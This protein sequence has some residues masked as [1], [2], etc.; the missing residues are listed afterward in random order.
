[1]ILKSEDGLTELALRI[2]K[3]QF[4][5]ILH[6][7]DANWLIL[8]VEVLTV[9]RSLQATD[10]CLLTWEAHWLVNWLADVAMGSPCD[11]ELAF[12]EPDLSFP[13]AVAGEDWLELSVGLGYGLLPPE[14][15]TSGREGMPIPL[16]ITPVALREC[17]RDWAEEVLGLRL[18]GAGADSRE[19][20]L[21]VVSSQ[22]STQLNV[23]VPE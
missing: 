19:L 14:R 8:D 15:Q 16:R 6:D 20:A 7:W 22:P 10:S 5:E 4:P 1:M 23:T 18:S 17:V 11:P 13:L 9:E 2:R 3:Y 12:L 21:A